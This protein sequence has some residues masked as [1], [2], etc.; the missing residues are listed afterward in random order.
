MGG[1][2]SREKLIMLFLIICEFLLRYLILYCD[3]RRFCKCRVAKILQFFY[4]I[5]PFVK[6]ITLAL[7]YALIMPMQQN[8]GVFRHNVHIIFK[9]HIKFV[10]LIRI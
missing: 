4:N 10:K 5:A 9:R 7:C 1:K 8:F 6:I 2:I 3:K